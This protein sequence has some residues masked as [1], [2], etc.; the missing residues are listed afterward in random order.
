MI[1]KEFKSFIEN[2]KIKK[3]SIFQLIKD[4]SYLSIAKFLNLILGVI[5]LKFLTTYLNPDQLGRY[6]FS[7]TIFTFTNL[8]LI[9]PFA[10]SIKRFFPIT[11]EK[12]FL[13]VLLKV[14]QKDIYLL[15][16]FLE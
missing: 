10:A 13:E 5:F 11:K 1:N 2:F 16:L 4:A 14:L 6:S 9:G 12:N 7:M 15:E 8:I 3:K